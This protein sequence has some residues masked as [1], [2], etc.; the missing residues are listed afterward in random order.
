MN[1]KQTEGD[2]AGNVKQRKMVRD[3]V[4][5]PESEYALIAEIK[6][7]CLTKGLAAKKSEVLRAALVSFASQN[8][9]KLVAA[10]QALEVIKTGR[11]SKNK[12]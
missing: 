10:I 6:Q 12:L 8:D 1:R 2:V 7:R 3:S 11:P 9:A 5:M 4:I